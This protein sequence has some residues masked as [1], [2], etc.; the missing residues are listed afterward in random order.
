M[1]LITFTLYSFLVP[2]LKIGTLESPTLQQYQRILSK[3][4]STACSCSQLAIRH[5]DFIRFQPTFH[6]VCSSYFITHQWIDYLNRLYDSS[7][8][9]PVHGDFRTIAASQ[10]STLQRLCQLV[11]RTVSQALLAFDAEY[12]VTSALLSRD[13]F[14]SQS[15]ATISAFIS[16]MSKDFMQTVDLVRATTRGNQLF[17]AILTKWQIAPDAMKTLYTAPIKYSTSTS[18]NTSECQC[19]EHEDSCLQETVVD[20]Q[21]I[22]G[23]QT[24]CYLVDALL[25]SSLEC[26]YK[27]ACLSRIG[28]NSIVALDGTLLSRYSPNATIG[29]FLSHM[30]VEE[31]NAN[32][33]YESYF[34][35]CNASDCTYSYASG[36]HVVVVMSNMIGLLGGLTIILGVVVPWA[37]EFVRRRRS[38]TA[39]SHQGNPNLCPERCTLESF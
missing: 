19:S 35:M 16:S 24:G 17:S 3:H 2:D 29:D 26:F 18:D 10:F 8:F 27:T 15:D 22:A 5:R 39:V 37:V 34:S 23:F 9:T 36:G 38:S 31:W 20:L 21:P 25:K 12:F 13:L 32:A 7:N 28:T 6:Q 1:S 33:A 11:N 4:P 14:Q 30:M